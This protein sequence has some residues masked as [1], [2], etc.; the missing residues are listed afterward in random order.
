MCTR[1]ALGENWMRIDISILLGLAP[2]KHNPPIQRQRDQRQVLKRTWN[3]P[4]KQCR[5]SIWKNHKRK[6]EESS[7]HNRCPSGRNPRQR[8]SGPPHRTQT[9]HKWN[10]KQRKHGIPRIPGCQKGIRQGMAGRHTVCPPQERSHGENLQMVKKLN[11]NLTGKI[12]TR[13]GLT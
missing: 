12:H 1:W 5:Q 3:N 7:K 10:Q 13:Q 8:D 2:R 6:S 11:S 9:N 4:S